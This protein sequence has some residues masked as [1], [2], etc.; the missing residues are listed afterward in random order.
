MI[1]PM[2][3]KSI[4]SKAAVFFALAVAFAANPASAAEEKLD[5]KY[6]KTIQSIKFSKDLKVR[7][8][9]LSEGI[10]MGQAKVAGKYGFGVV[11][12][13]KSYFWGINHRGISI[14]KRF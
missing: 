3:R 12:D 2:Q 5:L 14:S 7:G 9:K 6:N 10:Y 11:V 1:E 8:I 13:R 4:F